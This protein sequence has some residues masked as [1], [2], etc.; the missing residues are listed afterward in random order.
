MSTK[1]KKINRYEYRL[2]VIDGKPV[3]HPKDRSMLLKVLSEHFD[4]R[5]L[6][7]SF[8]VDY[9]KRSLAQNNYLWAVA[10]KHVLQGFIDAGTEGLR[11][12]KR[13]YEMIHNEVYKPKFVKN[14]YQLIDAHGQ[15]KDIPP[16]TKRQTKKE[17]MKS[18]DE[19]IQWAAEYL[20]VYIPLP[21]DD[22]QPVQANEKWENL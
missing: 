18:L 12:C 9:D 5:E 21:G 20:N 15:V 10:H 3:I 7:G 1:K 22:F 11:H 2:K 8:E 17:F 13:D 16:S 14:G 19:Y 6:I 4:G